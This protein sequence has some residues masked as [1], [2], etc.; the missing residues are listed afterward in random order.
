[1][2]K[3]ALR[4]LPSPHLQQE[5][6]RSG[7]RWL[8]ARAF[9]IWRTS[10]H[11][12]RWSSQSRTSPYRQSSAQRWAPPIKERIL[13]VASLVSPQPDDHPSANG[14]RGQGRLRRSRTGGPIGE[15]IDCPWNVADFVVQSALS[16]EGWAPASLIAQRRLAERERE[17]TRAQQHK[18]G[19]R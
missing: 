13:E 6:W 15:T 19:G 10:G 11:P 14:R 18:A 12:R 3:Q 4:R 16:L 17:Q 2:S 5:S 1:V 9:V 8:Q 7:R